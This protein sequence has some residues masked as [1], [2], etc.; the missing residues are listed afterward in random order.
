MKKTK[1]ICTLGPSTDSI[2]IIDALIKNGMDVARFNMSHNN[3]E[4]HKN[5]ARMVKSSREKYGSYCGLMLDTKGPEMRVG[6]FSEPISLKTGDTYTLTSHDIIGDNNICSISLKNAEK[7]IPINTI[8]FINDGTVKLLV[9]NIKADKIFCKVLCGGTLSSNKGVNIPSLNNALPFLTEADINDLKFAVDE[10]FDFI[11]A[12]FVRNAQDILN[13]K[14]QLNDYKPNDIKIIA[15]I[16]NADAVNNIDEIIA[17][18][19]GIMLAR[20]DL[21]VE[22]PIENIPIIQ[23]EIIK[24]SYS[25]GKM[26]IT[27]TQMLESMTNFSIPTRAETTDVAN[28]IFDGTS[29]VMLSGETAAG[30]YP[31]EALSM[32]NK[33]INKTEESLLFKKQLLNKMPDFNSEIT[34]SVAYSTC[35]TAKS[36]SASAILTT[37]KSGYTA[38]VLSSFRPSVPIIC[39]TSN[40]QLCYQ[41]NANWGVTPLLI[42]ES[43]SIDEIFESII[44]ASKS[45]GYIKQGDTIIVYSDYPINKAIKSTISSV[46]TIWF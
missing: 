41:L 34:P 2:D 17:I 16:E 20:G 43:E 40:I 12:S 19:D 13:L 44:S 14:I 3:L 30:K 27:A 5:R 6:K 8:I 28:A 18:S 46:F 9:Q 4:V 24:K 1:V 36:L 10:G 33:I 31:V 11:A 7:I 21:G 35:I 45:L 42:D 39:G 37:S 38:K 22:I 25:K 23:K 32:M 15:K 26:V 29:A